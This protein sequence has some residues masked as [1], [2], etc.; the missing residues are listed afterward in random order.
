MIQT[1]KALY[2]FFSGFGIAAYTSETVP[3]DATLPYLT[4]PLQEPEWGQK[5]TFY[6]T[7]YYRHQTSNFASLAKADEIVGAIGEGII[8]PCEGGYV[9][10]WPETPLVQELPPDGDVRG[11]YI[12]LSINA[13]HTHGG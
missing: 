8:L 11:A 13:Y 12:N 2:T 6:V 9:T 5:A 3:D 4:Y 7:V 10:I 1:A